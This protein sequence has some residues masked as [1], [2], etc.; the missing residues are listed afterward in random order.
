MPQ[1]PDFTATY[2]VPAAADTAR[3]NPAAYAAPGQALERL[4]AASE[5]VGEALGKLQEFHN[6]Q[7]FLDNLADF[8][9]AGF[10]K[11]ETAKDEARKAGGAATGFTQD[12][13]AQL[14]ADQQQRV[15]NAPSGLTGSRLNR[16]IGTTLDQ[17]TS[18]ASAFEH[19]MAVEDA[20]ARR[21]QDVEQTQLRVRRD[22]SLAPDEWGRVAGGIAA[23]AAAG[24]FNPEQNQKLTQAASNSIWSAELLGRAERDP[25]GAMADLRAGKYDAHID[26]P[27]QQALQPHLMTAAAR[28][29]NA[30]LGTPA[31]TAAG[32]GAGGAQPNA[33]DAAADAALAPIIQ[34][35]SGG[36]QFVGYTPPGTPPVDLSKAPLDPTGFPIWEGRMGPAG[37]S[38]AAGLYQIQ[39]GTWAPIARQ[40]G[41]TDFSAESQRAVARELYRQQGT[42]PWGASV[43]AGGDGASGGLAAEFARIDQMG[44]D[45][46]LAAKVKTERR[47]NYAALEAAQAHQQTQQA[48]AAKQTVE[49]AENAVIADAYAPTPKI[50]PQQVANDPAFASDPAARLRMI[51]V[52]K[53]GAEGGPAAGPSH[54][55][56]L[57]LIKRINL[58]DGDPQKI[59]DRAPL[60]DALA[61]N[62]IRDSDY[63][64]ALKQFNDLRDAGGETLARRKAELIKGVEPQLDKTW[65]LDRGR[66]DAKGA[67]RLYEFQVML[68]QRID[69]YQKA[70]KNP[71][72]L[73]TPGKPDYMGAPD[74][75]KPLKRTFQ[76]AVEDV[77]TEQFGAGAT[78]AVDLS[79][80][81]GLKAAV[82][83]GKI[84]RQA[85]EAEAVKRGW[86][87]A[88]APV[89][90]VAAPTLSVPVR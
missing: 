17:I 10:N 7:Y 16:R 87:A 39:P 27:T 43:A 60:V 15:E 11:L 32:S 65:L 1:V 90:P 6:T 3:A 48:R 28:G 24:L 85:G 52:I 73:L 56:T 82:A 79:T 88:P 50:T 12:L 51:A 66:K 33:T 77:D 61:N 14:K 19:G 4:G 59:T 75:L 35:E 23:S 37:I 86:I 69:E 38:H 49:A 80:P 13:V 74:V 31:I 34:R 18:R 83:A 47:I 57:E 21:L 20:Q 9:E 40:L 29:I 67:L 68:D 54:M 76:Q 84:T 58:P 5:G 53:N 55:A 89:A 42:A 63:T 71:F 2:S 64:F 62:Q 81:A 78:G 8:H 41:I 25:A 45:P 36:K 26:L 70:G 30:E 44:L 72:D 46:E 22:P